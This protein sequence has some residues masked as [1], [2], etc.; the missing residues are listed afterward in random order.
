MKSNK[1]DPRGCE[2]NLS[3][4]VGSLK[5]IQDFNL[6]LVSNT[7]FASKRAGIL[8]ILSLL[9]FYA[10][11]KVYFVYA[12]FATLTDFFYGGLSISLH[13]SALCPSRLI[14]LT[15]FNLLLSKTCIT[16]VLLTYLQASQSLQY[17]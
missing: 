2:R 9:S 11:T 4:C 13:V 12:T 3:N 15:Y 7:L 8:V 17:Q 14:R 5:K 1:N 6:P 10:S 16:I